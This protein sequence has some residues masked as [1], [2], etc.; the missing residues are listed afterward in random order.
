MWG[1]NEIAFLIVLLQSFSYIAMPPHITVGR[2]HILHKFVAN[3]F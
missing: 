2:H 1:C 3:S